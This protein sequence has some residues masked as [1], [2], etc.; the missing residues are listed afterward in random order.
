M[1]HGQAAVERGLSVNKEVLAPNLQEISLRALRLI[2]S[3]L[4]AKKIKV[5]DFQISEELLSSCNHASNRYKMFLMEKRTEK[6]HTVRGKKALEEEL[7]SAKKQE[8]LESVA[9]KLIDTGDK[10]AKEPAKQKDAT[11]MKALL[12]ESNALR[13]K[14]EKL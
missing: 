6:E 8:E 1:S 11:K 3:S 10:K 5:A 9:M 12:M 2:H 14:S 7:G 4:S 13:E